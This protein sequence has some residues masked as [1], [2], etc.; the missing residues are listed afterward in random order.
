MEDN[1]NYT[2][3]ENTNE[4]PENNVAPEPEA[5]QSEPQAQQPEPQVEQPEPQVEEVGSHSHRPDQ[6]VEVTA[7][8][9][10]NV[11]KDPSLLPHSTL[12]IVAFV[13]SLVSVLCCGSGSIVALIIA[14]VDIAKKDE[15]YKHTLSI[16]AIIISAVAILLGIIAAIIYF[17]S[18]AY[19]Q[20]RY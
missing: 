18:G 2:N 3:P 7:Q 15:E 5:T 17:A 14:I 20:T 6:T 16:A 10:Q 9:E 1:N 19:L 12:S 13:I 8:Y 4:T 11:P